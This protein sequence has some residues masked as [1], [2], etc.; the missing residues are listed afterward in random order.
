MEKG[1]KHHMEGTKEI[2]ENIKKNRLFQWWWTRF[3][4]LGI[5]GCCHVD[6]A[7]H[8]VHHQV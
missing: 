5:L 7:R 4:L 3:E 8:V 2:E 1:K 6:I